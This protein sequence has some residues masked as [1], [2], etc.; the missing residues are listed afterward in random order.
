MIDLTTTQ[1][2]V[3]A[4]LKEEGIKEGKREII[5]RLLIKHSLDETA[6]WSNMSPE[7]IREI[8]LLD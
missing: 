1:K 3:I 2:G 6:Q 4:T 7:E 5:N 8:Q